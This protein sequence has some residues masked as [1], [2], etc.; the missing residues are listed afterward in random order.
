M[1]GDIA[2]GRRSLANALSV[3]YR[4][5]I[6]VMPVKYSPIL[7]SLNA[8]RIYLLRLENTRQGPRAKGCQALLFTPA[9]HFARPFARSRQALLFKLGEYSLTPSSPVTDGEYHMHSEST[10]RGLVHQASS[11]NITHLWSV[12]ANPL[13]TLSVDISCIWKAF[14]YSFFAS[15]HNMS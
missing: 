1:P 11:R 10:H 2:Y 15:F 7:F 5:G 8:D 4:H 3:R 14:P 13:S 6:H 12:L 9:E